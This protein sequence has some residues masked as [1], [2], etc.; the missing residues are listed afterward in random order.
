MKKIL[1]IVGAIAIGVVV[2]LVTL[3][4]FV[5]IAGNRLDKESK[6][7]ADTAV[8]AIVSDWNENA[9]MTRASP[10]FVDATRHQNVDDFFQQYRRLGRMTS[11]KGSTGDSNMTFWTGSRSRIT[12]VYNAQ[13]MFENG[14]A[15]IRITLIKHGHDWRVMGLNVN[16]HLRP[17]AKSN[18]A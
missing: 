1:M 10:E 2:L 13:A 15:E 3:I 7:Y 6:A 18:A 17:P 12:A 9:L 16:C 14:T 5:A 11:Y 8:I 4:I